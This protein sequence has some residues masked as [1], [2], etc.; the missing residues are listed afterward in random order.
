MLTRVVSV[1]TSRELPLRAVR[2][3]VR[4][5]HRREFQRIYERAIQDLPGVCGV[6]FKD[7]GDR[8]EVFTLY[9]GD[10]QP[11]EDRIYEAEATL[12]RAFPDVR[13]DWRLVEADDSG[14]PTA[15]SSAHRVLALH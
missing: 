12:M 15:E 10:I 14:A 7:Q 9:R 1:F 8:L 11:V 5:V 6:Q 13:P 4:S 3:A 2:S